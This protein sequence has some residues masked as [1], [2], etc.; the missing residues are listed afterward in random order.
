MGDPFFRFFRAHSFVRFSVSRGFFVDPVFLGPSHAASPRDLAGGTRTVQPARF[1]AIAECLVTVSSLAGIPVID[2]HLDGHAAT[3]YTC[4]AIRVVRLR[5]KTSMAPLAIDFKCWRPSAPRRRVQGSFSSTYPDAELSYLV[6]FHRFELWV[7]DRRTQSLHSI[8]RPEAMGG[9]GRL[10]D[11]DCELAT[12]L[13]ND[14]IYPERITEISVISLVEGTQETDPR[15]DRHQCP[16]PGNLVN[17]FSHLLTIVPRG[18]TQLL[19]HKK[20]PKGLDY[21]HLCHVI[22]RCR[23][24][25][26]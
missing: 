18:G 12:V 1:G 8:S 19:W 5:G 4:R 11:P 13:T 16:A 10:A 2:N 25:Q 17:A 7:R 14:S 3:P 24:S 6:E 20:S 21:S 26:K 23:Q 22:C 15:L 9:L